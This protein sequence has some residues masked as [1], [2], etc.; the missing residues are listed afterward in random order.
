MTVQHLI[1]VMLLAETLF[2]VQETQHIWLRWLG[3]V[4]AV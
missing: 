4:D 2:Y 3:F 1:A